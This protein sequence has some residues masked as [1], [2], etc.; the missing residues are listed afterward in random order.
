MVMEIRLKVC[1]MR[2]A[3][4]ILAVAALVP[5]YM[6][7][8]FYAKSPR[9]VGEDFE[10]PVGFPAGIKK[11]GVFVNESVEKM[12][13]TGER[14]RLD[15]FQLHGDETVEVCRQLKEA[16]YGVIKVFSI[17]DAFDFDTTAS[18]AAA[19][20]FFLLAQALQPTGALLPERRPFTGKCAPG[21]VDRRYEYTR[22]RCE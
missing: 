5:E 13:E 21:R 8:I 15:Y 3:E 12:L 9:Y 6:G 20:D 1:G 19:V 14:L 16:G 2:D 17:G 22:A 7:F 18:Y 4:N 11:V 10:L